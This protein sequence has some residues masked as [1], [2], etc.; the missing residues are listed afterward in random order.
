MDWTDSKNV[1][2][3][4][5]QVIPEHTGGGR[6]WQKQG[7][8]AIDRTTAMQGL[9]TLHL[10]LAIWQHKA[11]EYCGWCKTLSLVDFG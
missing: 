5:P 8:R 9:K 6:F 4:G 2:R 11:V 1:I 10:F 3:A 7:I